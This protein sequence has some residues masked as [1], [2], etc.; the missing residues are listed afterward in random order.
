M[1]ENSTYFNAKIGSK[2]YFTK[3]GRYTT[4][5]ACNNTSIICR[6]DISSLFLCSQNFY[7]KSFSKADMYS[8]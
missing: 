2:M 1:A 7:L 3:V 6:L 8:A 4:T 5:Y